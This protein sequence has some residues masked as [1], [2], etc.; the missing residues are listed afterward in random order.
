[1]LLSVKANSQVI[2]DN[3]GLVLGRDTFTSCYIGEI[4][5][6]EYYDGG[7]NVFRPHPL[8]NWGNYKFFIDNTGRVGIHKKPSYKLDVKG[9]MSCLSSYFIRSDYRYKSEIKE[10]SNCLDKLQ[11]LEGKQYQ[12]LVFKDGVSD[13]EFE[14]MKKNGK[15]PEDAQNIKSGDDIYR[16]EFGFLADDLKRLFPELVYE[17]SVGILS[18]NYMGLIPV[19]VNSM[20]EQ[21]TILITQYEEIEK[22]KAEIS[23]YVKQKKYE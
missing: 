18:V 3:N 10:L 14:M 6:V 23:D 19:I 4:W 1:M 21:K 11:K 22:L 17:D 12:K 9:S 15:I 2:Y 7:F 8:Y 20:K 5:S 13:D 16:S